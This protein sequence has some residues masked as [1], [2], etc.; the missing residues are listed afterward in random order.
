MNTSKQNPELRH[1]YHRRISPYFESATEESIS[2][3]DHGDKMVWAVLVPFVRV[4]FRSGRDDHRN[5]K[6]MKDP[7]GE[8]LNARKLTCQLR[9]ENTTANRALAVSLDQSR[10]GIFKPIWMAD[11][12]LHENEILENKPRL[13]STALQRNRPLLAALNFFTFLF[14]A[15]AG[16]SFRPDMKKGGCHPRLFHTSIVQYQAHLSRD[17]TLT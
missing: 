2:S 6:R 14:L 16:I 3:S 9:T 7:R 8:K 15:A 12:S 5:I 10:K 4:V 13:A 17:R 1:P 11:E